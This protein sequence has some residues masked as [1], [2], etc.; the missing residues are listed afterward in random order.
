MIRGNPL[1]TVVIPTYYRNEFLRRAIE[2]AQ[3]Q[4]WGELEVIIVDDSGEAHAAA[5][6]EEYYVTYIAHKQNAGG[7]AARNTGIDA[8]DGAH[9]QLL[10]DD[11][12]LRP[13]KIERQLAVLT[14]R[15][16]V[17][18]AY[19]GVNKKGT[20][21]LPRTNVRG[22]ILNHVLAM[23]TGGCLVPSTMLLDAAVLDEVVPLTSRSASQDIGMKVELA[24]HTHFDFVNQVL[25]DRG[26]HG[27][28]V[29][30]SPVAFSTLLDIVDEY[31]TLYEKYPPEVKY[32]AL[33]RAHR[34]CGYFQLRD[35][36]GHAPHNGFDRRL[37]TDETVQSYLEKHAGD[38]ARMRRDYADGIDSSVERFERFVLDPLEKRGICEETLI[39]FA[40]DHGQ[41]L[42]EHSHVGES[43]PACPE[44]AYVPTTFVH[45]SL[46]ANER[47]ELFRHIDLAPTIA[48]ILET[49]VSTAAP[50]ADIFTADSPAYG[51]NFYD[52]PYP[53]FL[54]EFSYTI[55]SVWDANGGHVFVRSSSW[56]KLKLIAG[57]LLCIPA[58]EQVRRN[59]SLTAL[60]YLLASGYS[61]GEPA[62]SRDEAEGLLVAAGTSQESGTLEMETATQENLED[63]G[64]L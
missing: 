56:D 33:Y 10:D 17:D 39:I 12:T 50:G 27:E 14:N 4:S 63:L 6:A 24:K 28:Q 13:R 58:G 60:R 31:S 55:D 40:S 46:A 42:G 62:F 37:Q 32:Q 51:L 9:I 3:N 36:G 21:V 8:A 44:I 26:I 48:G 34:G 52:R 18:V 25:V 41:M 7:N 30:K 61:W 5:V 54:G 49:D 11:D 57:F 45:P 64:Y 43:Y 59:R 19:S 2:S 29:G 35:A 22:D 16:Q 15:E 47:E 38:D 53:S 1:V 20:E 23:R